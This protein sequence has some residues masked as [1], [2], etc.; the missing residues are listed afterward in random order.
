MGQ[1]K[2]GIG[3]SGSTYI[4]IPR[5]RKTFPYPAEIA[6]ATELKRDILVN[7]DEASNSQALPIIEKDE[8][9]IYTPGVSIP[10]IDWLAVEVPIEGLADLF[11]EVLVVSAPIRSF[12]SSSEQT[13]SSLSIHPAMPIEPLNI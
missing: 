6:N 3:V 7:D 13:F 4:K 1:K 12:K 8:Y 9:I 5:I 10:S 11:E 2:R